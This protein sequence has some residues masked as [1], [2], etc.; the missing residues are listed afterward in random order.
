MSVKPFLSYLE[1][2][3]RGDGKHILDRVKK[4]ICLS[5]KNY[6][7]SHKSNIFEIWTNGRYRAVQDTSFDIH[8]DI[9]KKSTFPHLLC[10]FFVDYWMSFDFFNF[11]LIKVAS[12]LL[13]YIFSMKWYIA[14]L[15]AL[16]LKLK[17]PICLQP[18]VVDL[19]YLKL[20]IRLD[21]IVKV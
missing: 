15:L 17:I 19:S 2:K 12:I 9:I 4:A 11:F 8:F 16:K 1:K 20:W 7:F 18:D 3:H 6:F 14:G 5:I 10:S 13:L 21:K